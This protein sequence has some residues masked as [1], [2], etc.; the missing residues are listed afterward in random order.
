MPN[1]CFN[2][3]VVTAK[4]EEELTAFLDFAE[5][6]HETR[7]K[8]YDSNKIE[9]TQHN[10][11]FWNFVTPTDTETYFEGSNAYFWNLENWDT[12]W[13]IELDREY[14]DIE[15]SSDSFYFV[16]SFDTAWSPA[17]AVYLAM[18]KRF[19]TLEFDFEITEEANFYAGK[20]RYE[21]GE[22]VQKVIVESPT[23]KDYEDL[24]IP[25]ELCCWADSGDCRN[26]LTESEEK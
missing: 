12:K 3:A 26:E 8:N 21:G 23:H 7:W 24:N 11:V 17:E 19:P 6:V 22:I 16:W 25:C 20:L 4:T 1:W 18:S 14:I 5:Q 9:I 13:D 10:G 15:S 2:R